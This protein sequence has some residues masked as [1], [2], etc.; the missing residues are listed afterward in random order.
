MTLRSG[1]QL[2]LRVVDLSLARALYEGIPTARVLARIRL[3]SDERDLEAV[4]RKTST[5]SWDTILARLLG[6]TTE[7]AERV[8]RAISRHARA[9]TDEG[10]LPMDDGCAAALTFALALSGDP[11]ASAAEIFGEA[12]RRP[13]EDASIARGCGAID[14]RLGSASTDKR[15]VLFEACARLATRA[16]AGPW[17]MERVRDAFAGLASSELHGNLR[18]SNAAFF[19][20]A[21]DSDVDPIDRRMALLER[22]ELDA[23][24]AKDPR[25]L[26]S[27]IARSEHALGGPPRPE[28]SPTSTARNANRSIPP[29]DTLVADLTVLL[30][31]PGDLVLAICSPDMEPET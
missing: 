9:A 30:R 2:E 28:S 14:P 8:K 25:E 27:A 3:G 18:R 13:S 24:V 16:L 19:P 1:D 12:P 10:S 4:P 15:A 11:D 21:F 22:A 5:S 7:P 17:A 29:L 6:G 23:L 26:A 20:L 31:N